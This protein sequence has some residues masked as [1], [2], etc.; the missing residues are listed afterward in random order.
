MISADSQFDASVVADHYDELDVFYRELWGEHVHHGL[1]GSGRESSEVAVRHLV[2]VV[3][4]K[5]QIKPG[6]QVIDIGCGYGAAARQLVQHY[7]A[8]VTAITLSSAQHVYAQSVTAGTNP[9]YLVAD[10]LTTDFAQSFQAAIA[11]ESSEHMPDRNEF[12][13]RAY[14]VLE[15][16]GRFV[17]CAW[18]SGDAPSSRE[19]AWLLRPICD[20]GKLSHLPTLN[21]LVASAKAAGFELVNS[22]DCTCSV[23]RTWGIVFRRMIGRVLTDSRYRDFLRDPRRRNRMFALTVV[24]LWLAYQVGA[25]RYGI[26]TLERKR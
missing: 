24:R 22:Q 8:E 11:I 5:A 17:V 1:W 9:V 7:G 3:A 2:D 16:G 12:F 4:K 25:M 26:I 23:R 10:W 20:E 14:K 21:E 13:R 6:D 15:T 19:I 18:L